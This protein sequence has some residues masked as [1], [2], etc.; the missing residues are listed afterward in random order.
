MSRALFIAIAVVF[1]L[2][3]ITGVILTKPHFDCQKYTLAQY[4][5][6]AVPKH[7]EGVK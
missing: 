4:A 2:G 6:G 7:C 3:L 1:F 5:N